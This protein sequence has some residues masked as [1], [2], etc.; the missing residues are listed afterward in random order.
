[1]WKDDS[2][3]ALRMSAR[4]KPHNKRSE[5]LKDKKEGLCKFIK[6]CMFGVKLVTTLGFLPVHKLILINGH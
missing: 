5:C 6:M 1:M 3:A 2:D 4:N